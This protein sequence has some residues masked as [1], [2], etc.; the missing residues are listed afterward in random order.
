MA[1][2]KS[3]ETFGEFCAIT[4]GNFFE[5]KENNMVNMLFWGI[6]VEGMLSLRV[7]AGPGLRT[8]VG[9][10]SAEDGIKVLECGETS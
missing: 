1:F 9:E 3:T 8:I 7:C 4:T 10:G 5:G 6:W 2:S